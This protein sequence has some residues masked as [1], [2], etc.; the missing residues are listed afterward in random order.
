MHAEAH[1]EESRNLTVV[2]IAQRQLAPD[3]IS[4]QLAHNRGTIGLNRARRHA[5][6]RV[7]AAGERSRVGDVAAFVRDYGTLPHT[8]LVTPDDLS[9]GW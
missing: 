3:A 9:A 5:P 6:E 1:A 7:G 4:A 8:W 2:L